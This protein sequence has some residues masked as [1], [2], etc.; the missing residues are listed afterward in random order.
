MAGLE[1]PQSLIL[2]GELFL[3]GFFVFVILYI[4]IRLLAEKHEHKD[5]R[6]NDM[7]R[8]IKKQDIKKARNKK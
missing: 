3:V 5:Q 8:I 4:L 7:D 6:F 2:G 1:I